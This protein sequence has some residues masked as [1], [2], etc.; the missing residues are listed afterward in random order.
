VSFRQ[1]GTDHRNISGIFRF[2]HQPFNQGIRG[3]VR[4]RKN[5]FNAGWGG[6]A[7]KP[8]GGRLTG[9][10]PIEDDGDAVGQ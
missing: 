4:G 3:Q 6:G 2:D 10:A 9:Q 7:I 5:N 1:I 8:Q